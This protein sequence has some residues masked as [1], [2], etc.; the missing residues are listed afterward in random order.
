[1]PPVESQKRPFNSD[2]CQFSKAI[3][4]L[5]DSTKTCVICHMAALIVKVGER[6]GR[7]LATSPPDC[8]A[9]V[10]LTSDPKAIRQLHHLVGRLRSSGLGAWEHYGLRVSTGP[11]MRLG[12]V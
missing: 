11:L 7:A 8:E 9:C 1:M 2:C 12:A 6:R 5:L 10:C 3:E 4:L